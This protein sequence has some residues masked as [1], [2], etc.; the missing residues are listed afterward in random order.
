FADDAIDLALPKFK[1]EYDIKL[2]STLK[3]M[4]MTEAFSDASDFSQLVKQGGVKVDEVIHKAFIEVDEVGTEAAA[5]TVVVIIETSVPALPT[6]RA[7]KPFLFVIRENQTN[8]ILFM[9]RLSDPT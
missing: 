4:G 5:V 1:M 9:G 3:A 2:K 8:S 7:D 6:V